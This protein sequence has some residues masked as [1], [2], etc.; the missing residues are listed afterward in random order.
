MTSNNVKNYIENLPDDRKILFENKDYDVWDF[1]NDDLLQLVLEGKKVATAGLLDQH[2]KIPKVG[3]FG[4]ITDSQNEPRCIVEYTDIETKP[5]L[6]IDF[7]FAQAEGE[8]FQDIEDWRS[9]H[10][11]VF[12]EWSGNTFTEN[13]L[14]LCENFK[15]VYK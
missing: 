6:E 3:D 15:L 13:D 1:G 5:F 14:I 9:E 10:R 11:K 8:G 7:H 12:K 4:I 2:T